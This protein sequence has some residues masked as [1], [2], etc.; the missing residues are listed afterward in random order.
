MGI[1]DFTAGDILE[2]EIE[3]LTH[4]RED[5]DYYG[6][7]ESFR[8]HLKDNPKSWKTTYREAEGNDLKIQV[9]GAVV[10]NNY[11]IILETTRPDD[12]QMKITG[13]VGMV[14]VRFE[15][16]ESPDYELYLVAGRKRQ[17]LD[18][19]VH[20]NDFWQ[21]DYD[22]ASDTYA[23]TYNLPLDKFKTSG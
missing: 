4:P 14:P 9:V 1:T 13:G 11:P 10:K 17:K 21:T 7:N 6:P 19:S 20:G 15:K 5:A 23:L 16:L 2:F 8:K 12:I 22:P 3:W 18:Q